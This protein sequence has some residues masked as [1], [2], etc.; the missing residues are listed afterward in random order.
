M[1]E[2]QEALIN[3]IVEKV[4]WERLPKGWTEDSV[5]KFAKSLTDKAGDEHGF[6]NACVA[7][8]KGNIDDPEG[9]CASVIDTYKGTTDWRGKKDIK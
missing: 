9:F 5:E 3:I 7:K 8:M 4:G 6:F 1:K 2:Q